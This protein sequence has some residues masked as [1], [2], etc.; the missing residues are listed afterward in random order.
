M[1]VLSIVISMFLFFSILDAA[2]FQKEAA[3]RDTKVHISSQK[4][5]STGS[6]VL[7]LDIKKNGKVLSG[8]KVMLKVFMP[9]MPSMPA[10]KSKADAQDL[11]NGKYEVKLNLS[12]SGT[13]Q[14]YIYI[15]PSV[16]KKIR[17]KTSVNI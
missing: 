16:G 14:V 11:G 8:A 15:T 1:K 17:V 13:W 2:A 4:Q 6:N 12:M 5:L 10:M 3:S 9:A 7:M